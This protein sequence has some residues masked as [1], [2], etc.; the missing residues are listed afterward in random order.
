[1]LLKESER[2]EGKKKEEQ[3]KTKNAIEE[4]KRNFIECNSSATAKHRD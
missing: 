3:E 1:M 2:C 4:K